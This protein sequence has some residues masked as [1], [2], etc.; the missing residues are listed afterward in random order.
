MEVKTPKSKERTCTPE[1][2]HFDE[3]LGLT[4]DG[5]PHSTAVVASNLH[6]FLQLKFTHTNFY[7]YIPVL[8]PD[9]VTILLRVYG[10]ITCD[11]LYER[12]SNHDDR[13]S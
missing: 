10:N 5:H 9:F 1:D 4:A 12:H 6:N 7:T 11:F 8:N 13:K 2:R 3:W